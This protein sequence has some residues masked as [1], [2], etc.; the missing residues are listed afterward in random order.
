MDVEAAQ[1]RELQR[2]TENS[3]RIQ[4]EPAVAAA[5]FSKLPTDMCGFF[6]LLSTAGALLPLLIGG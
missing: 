4:F 1:W 5:I 3:D 6:L 2:L